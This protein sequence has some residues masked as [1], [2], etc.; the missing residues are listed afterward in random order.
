LVLQDWKRRIQTLRSS[1]S[2]VKALHIHREF[3]TQA[4][5]LSKLGLSSQF[6]LL[7]VEE[8]EE[9]AL[10]SSSTFSPF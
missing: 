1:F 10:I 8:F 7:Q 4:D 5:K 6:G 2:S 3:N 9:E